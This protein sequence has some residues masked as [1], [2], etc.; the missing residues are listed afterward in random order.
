MQEST[1]HHFEFPQNPKKKTAKLK[2][3]KYWSFEEVRHYIDQDSC[4]TFNTTGL[5]NIDSTDQALKQEVIRRL[6]PIC[7]PIHRPKII[8]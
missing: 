3:C 4:S 5:K 2:P 6:Q 1:H 7:I 8:P